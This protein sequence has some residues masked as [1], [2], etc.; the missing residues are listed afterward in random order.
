MEGMQK[1]DFSELTQY[2]NGIRSSIGNVADRTGESL[3]RVEA[4]LGQLTRQLVKMNTLLTMLV[5][6]VIVYLVVKLIMLKKHK[7]QASQ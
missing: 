3:W 2:F 4:Q 6:V 7:S 1:V 5:V